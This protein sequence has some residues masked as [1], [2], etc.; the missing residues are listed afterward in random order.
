MGNIRAENARPL[1]SS[2]RFHYVKLHGS[3]NWR[4]SDGRDV[5]V[6][7]RNKLKRIRNEPLLD[8]YFE[9]FENVLSGQGRCLLVIGYG[10]RDR[11]INKVI[12]RSIRDHGLRLY[13]MLPK[14]QQDFKNSLFNNKT[15]YGKILWKGLAS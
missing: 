6:I 5:M 7:G 10:F 14:D 9:T 3:L 15:P 13:V 4:S 2:G 12:A 8:Y 1:S 11:H